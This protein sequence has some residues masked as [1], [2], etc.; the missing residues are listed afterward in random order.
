MAES[1]WWLRGAYVQI[2]LVEYHLALGP[3]LNQSISGSLQSVY[4]E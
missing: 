4:I 1:T 3:K 2:L